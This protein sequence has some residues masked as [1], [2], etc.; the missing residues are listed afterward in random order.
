MR[1]ILPEML[2]YWT[3]LL[4]I[5]IGTQQGDDSDKYVIWVFSLK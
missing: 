4:L 5:L 2:I 3:E 1:Q